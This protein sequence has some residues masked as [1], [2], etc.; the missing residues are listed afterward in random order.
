[1]VYYKFL[2][3]LTGTGGNSDVMKVK[4]TLTDKKGEFY[5]PPYT[6]LIQPFSTEDKAEFIFFKPGYGGPIYT[7]KEMTPDNEE[8]YFSKE[9]GSTGQLVG[10]IDNNFVV[11]FGIVELSKLK[12]KEERLNA[13]RI[14]ITDNDKNEAP[15]LY[16]ALDEERKSLGLGR[17]ETK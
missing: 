3:G 10:A 8:N 5:F 7:S 14:S 6:T 4:E 9:I 13:S 1:V 16:K 11:I 12:T 17:R 2:P 15:L